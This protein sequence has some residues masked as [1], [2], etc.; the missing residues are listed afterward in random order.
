[1]PGLRKR[2]ALVPPVLLRY[3]RSQAAAVNEYGAPNF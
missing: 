2:A 1:M 3:P